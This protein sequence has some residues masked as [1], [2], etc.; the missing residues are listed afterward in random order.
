MK[1]AVEWDELERLPCVIKLLPSPRKTVGLHDF[2][3]LQW[4]DIELAARR[5]TVERSDWIGHVNRTK[6]GTVAELPVTQRLTA[7]LKPSLAAMEN[8]R[9]PGA[10]GAL[11]RSRLRLK[12]D[13]TA[14]TRR[15]LGRSPRS[16]RARHASGA[17]IMG[18]RE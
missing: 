1:R 18:P 8:A 13:T 5:L 15:G 17:G 9:D 6:R 10:R 12:P 14:A 7:A 11:L 16:E 4:R 2:V 3:A